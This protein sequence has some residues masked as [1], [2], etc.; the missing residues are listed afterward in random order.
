MAIHIVSIPTLADLKITPGTTEN[1]VITLG[2][3]SKGDSRGALYYFDPDD[4]TTPE[5]TNYY[6]T[7][8]PTIGNGRWKKVFTRMLSLPHGTL[9]M[10]AGKKEF[11]AT[12]TTNAS[13]EVTFNLTLDGTSTGTAIFTDIWFNDG[14]AV[15]N[16]ATANDVVIGTVKSESADKK[17]TIHKFTKGKNTLLNLSIITTGLTLGGTELPPQGT[18]IKLKVEGI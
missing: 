18:V 8:V 5:D 7:V 3:A 2:Q 14:K 6:N 1:I 12:G 17:Q 15:V 4:N 11:F 9:V 16:A 10:N 13:G